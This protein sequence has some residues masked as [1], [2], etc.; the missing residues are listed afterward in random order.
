MLLFCSPG[1]LQWVVWFKTLDTRTKEEKRYCKR[2]L[3]ICDK[4]ADAACV[5][6]LFLW[7]YSKVQEY[8]EL[9][10]KYDTLLKEKGNDETG[11]H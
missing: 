7:Y 6:T 8:N 11:N 2:W 10:A 1:L 5:A 3:K 4:L 9:K